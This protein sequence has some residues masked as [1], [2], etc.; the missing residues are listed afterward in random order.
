MGQLRRRFARFDRQIRLGI[1]S[2]ASRFVGL[3]RHRTAHL[4]QLERWNPA[5][6]INTKMGH[7]FL[8]NRLTGAPLL[9]VEERRVPQSDIA[10]DRCNGSVVRESVAMLMEA[11]ECRDK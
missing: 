4:D 3:R 5:V 11:G 6:V 1:S 8:L 9:P 10:G 7:V 2:R